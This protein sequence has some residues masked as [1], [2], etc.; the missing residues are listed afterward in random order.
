M[1]AKSQIPTVNIPSH[2]LVSPSDNKNILEFLD[3]NSLGSS[4]LTTS[5]AFKKIQLSSK[6]SSENLTN[7][8]S[9]F[10]DRYNKVNNLYSGVDSS[11]D[12]LYYGIKRQHNYTSRESLLNN[13]SGLIDKNSLT[14]VLELNTGSSTADLNLDSSFNAS[15]A[16]SPKEFNSS[17]VKVDNL[18][19]PQASGLVLKGAEAL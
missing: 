19:T 3:F 10:S 15:V 4:T 11:Q 2:V 18:A 8:T 14:K 5:G 12:A 9:E 1:S 13:T 16:Q 17:T 6:F 7:L